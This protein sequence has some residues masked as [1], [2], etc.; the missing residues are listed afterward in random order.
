MESAEKKG[1]KSAE[2]LGKNTEMHMED[3]R[4][5]LGPAKY[6]LYDENRVDEETG[7]EE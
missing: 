2:W 4:S 5:A 3:L 1:P 7:N 6:P